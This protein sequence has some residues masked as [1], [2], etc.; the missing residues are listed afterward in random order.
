MWNDWDSWNI[1]L[2]KVFLVENNNTVCVSTVH[3]IG[4][5]R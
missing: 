4:S 2:I 1:N 5:L 3:E